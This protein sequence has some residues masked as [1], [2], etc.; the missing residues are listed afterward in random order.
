MNA[1]GFSEL[2]KC[3]ICSHVSCASKGATNAQLASKKGHREQ[4]DFLLK[5]STRMGN[6]SS[7]DLKFDKEICTFR[8]LCQRIHAEAMAGVSQSHLCKTYDVTVNM[9]AKLV[10]AEILRIQWGVKMHPNPPV[11]DAPKVVKPKIVPKP[12]P[13]LSMKEYIP[14]YEE[15]ESDTS[16]D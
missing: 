1:N 10:Q 16:S 6:G 12:A 11:P 4:L 2:T 14:M 8:N 7:H 9:L 13:N 3:V 5:A 15:V